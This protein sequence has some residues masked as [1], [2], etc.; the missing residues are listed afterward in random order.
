M[1]SLGPIPTMRG[2]AAGERGQKV[3]PMT[4]AQHASIKA[5]YDMSISLAESIGNQTDSD[6]KDS[7]NEAKNT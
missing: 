5:L 1:S 6:K 3:P 4:P 2:V 7:I